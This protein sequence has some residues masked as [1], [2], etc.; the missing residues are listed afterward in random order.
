MTI[1]ALVEHLVAF[2]IIVLAPI[3]AMRQFRRLRAM[4][5]PTGSARRRIY[6]GTIVRQWSVTVIALWA[7][8]S[9]ERTLAELGLAPPAGWSFLGMF[10]V[11]SLF[12][13]ILLFQQHMFATGMVS[14]EVIRSKLGSIAK[15]LP[16]DLRDLRVFGL[17]ALT[18]GVC[19]E[20]LFRGFL[21]AYFAQWMA[22]PLALTLSCAVF[23]M[24]HAYQ[25]WS[26]IVK[27]T[28]A[29]AVLALSYTISGSL[30]IG[31]AAHAL[32]DLNAGLLAQQAFG[33]K[34]ADDDE[35]REERGGS[36]TEV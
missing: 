5:D 28:V 4:D 3:V 22:W 25:G 14:I 31:M 34:R 20:V 2:A 17:V 32:L 26:G 9:Q 7:A 1:A 11:L 35:A 8:L 16:H 33:R 18:A 27:T 36:M 6:V 19:E 23:G 21:V 29:G 24:A 13:A 12:M 15:V 10:A 30:W